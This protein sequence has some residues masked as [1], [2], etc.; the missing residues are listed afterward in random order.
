MSLSAW[1][2][3]AINKHSADY[4]ERYFFKVSVTY[5]TIYPADFSAYNGVFSEHI[6]ISRSVFTHIEYK[7]T[8]AKSSN[9]MQWLDLKRQGTGIVVLVLATKVAW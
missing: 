1:Q 7:A 3:W 8:I 4:K 2:C 6:F 9:E 5:H